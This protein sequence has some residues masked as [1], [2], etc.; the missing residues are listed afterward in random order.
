[1][2]KFRLNNDAEICWTSKQDSVCLI[3]KDIEAVFGMPVEADDYKVSGQWIFT[4]D[5]GNVF[6][7]Y[8]WK[9]TNLYDDDLP[10]VEE[11]RNSD[12]LVTFSIGGRIIDADNNI[13]T[14][15]VDEFKVW[16]LKTLATG[17]YFNL[18]EE[19]NKNKPEI[20]SMIKITATDLDS[21]VIK[22][23]GWKDDVLLVQFK[24][25]NRIYKYIDVPM[26][27]AYKLIDSFSIGR[28]F[29]ANIKN[30]YLDKPVD[31]NFET[32]LSLIDRK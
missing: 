17:V 30:N 32:I 5:K 2:S 24:D 15:N 14:N 21:S 1:M 27:E 11:F 4:D 25:S 7:L 20:K 18:V 23:I 29:N 19:D 8:D 12:E 26:E 9:E 13:I 6:T 16:L 3:Y 31:L 28:Y 10:S 22:N